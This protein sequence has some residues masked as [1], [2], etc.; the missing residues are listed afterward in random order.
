MMRSIRSA[1]LFAVLIAWMALV[2]CGHERAVTDES[3]EDAAREAV[4]IAEDGS[5]PE[6]TVEERRDLIVEKT[7]RVIDQKTGQVLEE[8]KSRTPVTITR[9]KTVETD[10]NVK[11]GDTQTT[12]P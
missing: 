4:G 6:K 5:R 3:A 7:E 2:G 1:A 8:E 12:N 11:T 10:V 9:E